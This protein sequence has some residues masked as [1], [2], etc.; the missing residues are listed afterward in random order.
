MKFFYIITIIFSFGSLAIGQKPFVEL[1]VSSNNVA[2]GESFTVTAKSNIG[3]N[4]EITFPNELKP[5]YSVLNGMS[6]EMDYTSGHFVSLFYITKDASFTKTGKFSVGPAIVRKGGKVYKSNEVVVTVE[7][8][9]NRQG[10]PS[11]PKNNNGQVASNNN[12]A[13]GIIEL[14][15]RKL[16][17]GEPLLLNSNVYARFR[18]SQL[19]NYQSYEVPDV[20]DVHN[21]DN[22]SQINLEQKRINGEALFTFS[23]DRK[24]VFPIKKGE[25]KVKPFSLDLRSGFGFSGYEF[26]SNAPTYEVI[27]LPKNAPSYFKGGVGK[28]SISRTVSNK[29]FKQGDVI[30]LEFELSGRGN[31]HLISKPELNLPSTIQVYGDPI[32]NEKIKF[33]SNGAEGKIVYKYN[34]QLLDSGKLIIPK[35]K[36]AYFSPEQ[37]KYITIELPQIELLVKGDPSFALMEDLYQQDTLGYELLDEEQSEEVK[38]GKIATNE[39]WI[40]W[41]YLSI[42]GFVVTLFLILYRRKR[43]KE[44]INEQEFPTNVHQQ[45]DE[46]KKIHKVTSEERSELIYHLERSLDNKNYSDYYSLLYKCIYTII[47]ERYE[48]SKDKLYSYEELMTCIKNDSQVDSITDNLKM[49]MKKAEESKYSPFIDESQIELDQE[50]FNKCYQI[51][52][53]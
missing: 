42:L 7:T 6:Q 22:S 20:M 36:Y 15:K 34:I 17:E 12:P 46:A 16:Y 49:L 40:H 19:E 14:S 45:S 38:K 10:T 51:L 24:V 21:L 13:F 3:G 50:M 43:K 30:A 11:S 4:I 28:F 32:V 25:H 5:G 39:S 29:S 48:L 9:P 8:N 53:R 1:S 41:L 18:P 23:L 33:N 27:P 44:I 31:L 47:L 2:V 37:E 52:I 26:K 35:L